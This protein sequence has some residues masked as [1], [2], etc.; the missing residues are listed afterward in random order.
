M[1]SNVRLHLPEMLDYLRE[2]IRRDWEAMIACPTMSPEPYNKVIRA[3]AAPMTGRWAESEE[4]WARQTLPD[5]CVGWLTV[6]SPGLGARLAQVA[7]SLYRDQQKGEILHTSDSLITGVLRERLPQVRIERMERRHPVWNTVALWC[8]VTHL[9]KQTFFNDFVLSKRSS[10]THY[11]GSVTEPKV[12][13]FFT[14]F[15]LEGALRAL[16]SISPSLVPQIIW[17]ICSR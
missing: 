3:T 10:S 13:R 11:V 15:T 2:N 7:L 1:D 8:P 6:L 12:W 5:F 16:E 17:D 9:F 14:C 4:D